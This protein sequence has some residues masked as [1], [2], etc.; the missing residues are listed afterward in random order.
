MFYFFSKTLYY[1]LT[2]AGWLFFSLLGAI[3][4]RNVR[5]RKRLLISSLVVF[6]LLG[7]GPLTNE[8][9]RVWEIESPTLPIVATTGSPRVAV[10][11]TGNM[12][13]ALH[14]PTPLRPVLG[15]EADRAGQALWLY[16]TCRVQKIIISGG[17]G[18]MVILT[19]SAVDEGQMVRSFLETAGVRAGDIVLE[20]R[21]KNT[22]ENARFSATVLR[23]QFR[24]DACV[25]VTSA[26]HMRRAMAC[27]QRQGLR[28]TPWPAAQLSE[29]R[30]VAPGAYLL[31]NEKA[32]GDAQ[33]L[34]REMVGYVTYWVAGY[35]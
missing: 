31:P 29:R 32:F 25:V 34:F 11:L 28:V 20:P 19:P 21:S 35:L 13:N 3:F 17:Q 33:L 12:I 9:M 6:W 5:W 7:N 15:R 22:Y 16:K 2:P 14:E 24:T 10:V 4:L 26:W 23:E 8:L 30:A 1:L 18:N 27:F